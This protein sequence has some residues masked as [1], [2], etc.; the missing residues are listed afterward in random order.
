MHPLILPEYTDMHGR[1]VR[2][3]PR[4]TE[5]LTALLRPP[6]PVETAFPDR[7]AFHPSV[8]S[9]SLGVFV[10]H[11]ALWNADGLSGGRYS[12][13]AQVGEWAASLGVQCLG[14]LP[15][16]PQFLDGPPS[17]FEPSPYA[18]VS[19]HFWAEHLIDVE[20][21]PEW[22]LST[23]ARQ[24]WQKLRGDG[25]LAASTEGD[26]IDPMR[27]WQTLWPVLTL[28]A[29]AAAGLDSRAQAVGLDPELLEQYAVFRAKTQIFGSWHTWSGAETPDPAQVQV[30]KY[31][32]VLAAEQ[33]HG[34]RARLARAGVALYLDLPIGTHPDGFDV[35]FGTG[36]EPLHVLGASVGA[37]PDPYFPDG[38]DWGFSPVDPVLSA[39]TEHAD[40]RSAVDH[41]ARI[42]DLLRIDHILGLYRLYWIPKGAERE[43]AYV[44]NPSDGW[45][46]ALVDG[47]HRHQCEIIGEN[48][49]ILP[50]KLNQDM[51]ALRVKGLYVGQFS[52]GMGTDQPLQSPQ[53]SDIASLNTHDLPTFPGWVHGEDIAQRHDLGWLDK[54]TALHALAERRHQVHHLMNHAG[55]APNAPAQELASALYQ[56]LCRSPA[57]M[58]LINLEDLWDERRPH[59]VPGTWREL[60]NWKRKLRYSVNDLIA[61]PDV[62]AVVSRCASL[63]PPR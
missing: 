5:A 44:R 22:S 38:Q 30:W 14:T 11:H 10:P 36:S 15:M 13:L 47:S 1:P 37:P 35:Y 59:N 48:L 46:K 34:L 12:L 3:S 8:G 32:Q 6:V 51:A 27:S 21:A 26:L 29:Q 31:A 20:E 50:P 9:P 4:L 58:V 25:V 18:P 60:P 55:C 17:T 28:L 53:S 62:N 42:A 24:A 45:W 39:E 40:F 41:H 57:S 49:G 43:G 7:P 56:W 61:H 16:L 23:D 54:P 33:V 2:P 19:R 52:I 63:R